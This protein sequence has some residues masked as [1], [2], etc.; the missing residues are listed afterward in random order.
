MAL[1][2]AGSQTIERAA[3]PH[4]D[5]SGR[6]EGIVSRER[7]RSCG[8]RSRCKATPVM[9]NSEVRWS[10]AHVLRSGFWSAFVV[11][12]PVYAVD[13]SLGRDVNRGPVLSN[14]APVGVIDMPAD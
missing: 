4:R 14:K 1:R 3:L 13:V 10:L 12:L 2:M 11:C 6:R 5:L 9:D 8:A 7:L